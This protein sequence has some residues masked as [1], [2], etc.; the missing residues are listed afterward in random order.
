MAYRSRPEIGSMAAML[1][2]AFDNN[3]QSVSPSAPMTRP[4]SLR[5]QIA[6]IMA[7]LQQETLSPSQ[8]DSLIRQ[9][10]ELQARAASYTDPRGAHSQL[11]PPGQRRLYY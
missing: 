10:S 6:R 7:L 11:G 8:R 5:A 9:L 1:A 3:T 4:E 2:G